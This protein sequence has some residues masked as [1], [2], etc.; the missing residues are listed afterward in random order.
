MTGLAESSSSSSM[1]Q[2]GESEKEPGMHVR[3]RR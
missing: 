2:A 1:A 3:K